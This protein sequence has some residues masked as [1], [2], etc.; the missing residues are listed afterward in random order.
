MVAWKGR[1]KIHWKWELSKMM[2]IF[3]ISFW[4]VVT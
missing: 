3:H 2:Q 4:V 1:R